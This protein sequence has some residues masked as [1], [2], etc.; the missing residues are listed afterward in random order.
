[1]SREV[2]DT[3]RSDLYG[4]EMLAVPLFLLDIDIDS[5]TVS[6]LR[7]VNNNEDIVFNSN[8]YTATAFD[9]KLPEETEELAASAQLSICNIDRRFLR[10]FRKYSG[11][12]EITARIVMVGDTVEE[13]AGPFF[14]TL[15]TI[16]YD[17]KTI[18][19]TLV[20]RFKYQ[21]RLAAFRYTPDLFPGLTATK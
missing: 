14:Y 7:V 21:R 19:G 17:S 15:N 9:F 13:V 18:T 16:N 3:V 10:E 1:M 6:T 2:T 5:P 20:T 4:T 12:P 8:T 11:N